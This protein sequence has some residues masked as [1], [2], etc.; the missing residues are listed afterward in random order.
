MKTNLNYTPMQ[1]MINILQS[2]VDILNTLLLS[3]PENACTLIA[4]RDINEYLKRANELQKE[5][6][7]VIKEAYN[8][9]LSDGEYNDDRDIHHKFQ[10]A[11]D[12]YANT[13]DSV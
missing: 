11:D 8:Q 3:D 6:K 2:N 10:N 5:E 13:F 1:Q 12:Y 7:N 9:G 4:I